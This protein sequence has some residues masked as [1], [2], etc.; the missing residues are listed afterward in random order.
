MWALMPPAAALALG[1]PVG[2]SMKIRV[3][4]RID[5]IDKDWRGIGEKQMSVVELRE[6]G[7]DQF[8]SPE[9]RFAR[10]LFGKV[11]R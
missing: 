4:R 11:H 6:F 3:W 10:G 2:T 9:F 8:Q 7:I 5:L 1:K